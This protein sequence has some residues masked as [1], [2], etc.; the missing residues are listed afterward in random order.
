MA[1][2]FTGR[3]CGAIFDLYV[4]Y[5][6]QLLSEKLQDLTTFQTPFGALCLVTLPIRWMNLVPIF[7]DMV[8][9]I[10]Q[11]EIPE[12]TIPYIND[13]PVKGPALQKDN[14]YEVIE[15]NPGVRQFVWEHLQVLNSIIQQMKYCGGTF[16]GLKLALCIPEIIV[17]G[18]YCTYKG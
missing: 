4:G 5:N 10:L 1:E 12:W 9:F 2:K 16:S 7:H 3:A 18:H 6:E 13:I 11:P 17:V 8:T 15:E 14:S